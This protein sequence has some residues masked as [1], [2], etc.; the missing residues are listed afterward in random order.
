MRSAWI[1]DLTINVLKTTGE[2]A[3]AENAQGTYERL[4]SYS[5]F[6]KYACRE[7]QS[8][9]LEIEL[10]MLR[11]YFK[12]IGCDADIIVDKHIDTGNIFVE[13]TSIISF[14]DNCMQSHNGIAQ[15]K[16]NIQKKNDDAVL[17]AAIEDKAYILRLL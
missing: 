17:Y 11:V 13:R 1:N 2:L 3:C 9:T 14:L 7:S 6:Y 10:S 5:K 4:T 15:V 16:I 12:M 8:A